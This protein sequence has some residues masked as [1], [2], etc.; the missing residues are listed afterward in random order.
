ML[1]ILTHE[2]S[3]SNFLWSSDNFD[4][5]GKKSGDSYQI[6]ITHPNISFKVF[7][8][9]PLWLWKISKGALVWPGLPHDLPSQLD[10]DDDVDYDN[11]GDEEGRVCYHTDELILPAYHMINFS[12]CGLWACGWQSKWGYGQKR[13]HHKSTPITSS[14]KVFW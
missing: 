3:Q 14:S 8:L 7:P 1:Q 9:Q 13:Y 2:S 12:T 6:H 10:D 11:Y 4:H 5:G